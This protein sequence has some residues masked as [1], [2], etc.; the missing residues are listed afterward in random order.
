MRLVTRYVLLELLKVFAVALIALTALMVLRGVFMQAKDQGLGPAQI[1]RIVPFLLPDMLRYTIPATILFAACTVYGRMS[2]SNEV[3]A[4]KSLGISP[5]AVVAP[6]LLLSFALSLVSFWLN[7]VAVTWGQGGVQRVAIE[8]LEEIAY[9]TLR[10][11]KSF[12]SKQFSMAVQDVEGK[13]LINPVI[14]FQAR[15][16]NPAM[17]VTAAEAELISDPTNNLLKIVFRNG[18]AE[19][20]NGIKFRFLEEIPQVLKLDKASPTGDNSYMPARMAMHA[21]PREI[22]K[23][24]LQIRRLEQEY[25]LK[26]A[27]NLLLG[28]FNAV[29]NTPWAAEL[30]NLQDKRNHLHRLRTEPWRRMAGGF[31]C[32]CFVMIGAPMAIRLRNAD[33]LTSFIVC[34]LPILI[35][36]YPLFA[37]GLEQAKNG[38]VHPATVWLGNVVVAAWGL[39]LLRRVVRY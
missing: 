37:F 19:T 23:T 39:V 31:S 26:S 30:Q 35:G 24:T 28:D 21:I 15:D 34:F 8:A 25:A 29:A 16:D 6:G 11:Q 7:D 18:T 1:V 12:S 10:S 13:R 33:L 17:T 36:Y 32:L 3:V 14:S 38:T 5:M 27:G 2:S 22:E 20:E 4:L 9:S